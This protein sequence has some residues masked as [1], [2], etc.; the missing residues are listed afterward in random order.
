MQTGCLYILE[1]PRWHLWLVALRGTIYDPDLVRLPSQ[2]G[3]HLLETWPVEESS[4]RDERHYSLLINGATFDA[5]RLAVFEHLPHCPAPKVDVE[6][7]QM[8]GV[9]TD[10]P[11]PWRPPIPQRSPFLIAA[12]PA[13]DPAAQTLCLLLVRRIPDDDRDLLLTLDFVRPPA[14]L[15]YRHENLRQVLFLRKGVTERVGH[16]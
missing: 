4:Y 10:A 1:D 16:I 7:S 3:A 11:L 14:R 5:R 2:F 6:I 15:A 12:G 8:L 9:S 13:L